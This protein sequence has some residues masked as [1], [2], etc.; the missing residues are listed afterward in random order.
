MPNF[1]ESG[2]PVLSAGRHRSA[3]RGACFME[4]ASHLAGVRWSDHPTCTHPTIASVARLVNDLTSS[5]ARQRLTR[6]ITSVVGLNGG[7]PRIPVLVSAL[8]ASQALPIASQSRQRALA[9]ALIRCD[10]LMS[11]WEGE[12]IERARLRTRVAFLM[13]PGVEEWAAAFVNASSPRVPIPIHDEDDAIL[14]TSAIAIADA[15]VVDADARLERLLVTAIEECAALLGER[16]GEGEHEGEHEGEGNR[17]AATSS[18]M[19]RALISV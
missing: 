8:V 17:R 7:D 1:I 10:A 14:R 19:T 13:T 15:C 11:G 3:R 2:M 4:Y 5:G 6:H 9:T 12:A 16:E 18:A